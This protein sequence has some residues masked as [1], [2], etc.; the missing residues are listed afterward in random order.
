MLTVIWNSVACRRRSISDTFLDNGLAALKGHLAR[1]GHEVRVVDW[2]TDDFYASLS[3][4]VIARP[5]R[6]IYSLLMRAPGRVVKAALGFLS[7]GLQGLLSS[8]QRRRLDAR[9]L[10]LA[11]EIRAEG[12]KVVGIKVWYGEAFVNAARLAR[13][14]KELA[15]D[16]ILIAGGYH[17]T[18][19]EGRILAQAP[20][21]LGVEREGEQ[22]LE[23]ILAI[24]EAH[25][26]H[27]DKDAVLSEI[28]Q[29]AE[30][31]TIANLVYR[32]DGG[33]RV[34][35]RAERH[36]HDTSIPLYS[37]MKGKVRIHVVTDSVGCAWGKCHFCVHRQFSSGFAMRDVDRI[38]DE[39]QAMHNQ[40]VR[41]FRFA[42]SDTPP[43]FGARIARRLSERR[44]SVVFGMGSRAV[45]GGSTR[46]EELVGLY[47]DLI[48][49]GLRA[50]F[51]GGETGN[52]LVNQDVMNKGLGF[53]DI[54]GS[55]RA[56]RD[57]ERATG[58][59][60][61]LSLALIYPTP[62]M[63]KVS[64]DDVRNDNVALLRETMPDSVMVTPPGPFP[65]ST[66]YEEKDRFGFQVDERAVL[67]AMRYEYVLY[68]PP[69][70]WP[71]LGITLDGKPF[72]RILAECGEFRSFVQRELGIPTDISDE[73]FLMFYA[74]GLRDPGAILEAK[75][76]TV[77]DIL[78]CDYSWTRALSAR[79]NRQPDLP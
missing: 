69:Q 70:F 37:D 39:I 50:L 75:N 30:R 4:A 28:A 21:D 27:W 1:K 72:D 44:V 76:Q 18:L 29:A 38:G 51:M 14:I 32:R 24:A 20:F 13:Y 71:K 58:A 25:L 26:S 5:L 47:A 78:S 19:Y 34:S 3:P 67:D 12:I 43:A 23:H 52:D 65:H 59:K 62:L 55:V 73:H 68:K 60:V 7:I 40:G 36:A 9:L 64:L 35:S 33:I 2:A 6:A 56:L 54:V 45:K 42:G 31:G 53:Q 41:V 46:H 16:A 57:A 17:V 63:G 10:R 61:F 48:R 8:V 11:R 74:A 79:V 77:L 15:P 49:G 66:W 22:T